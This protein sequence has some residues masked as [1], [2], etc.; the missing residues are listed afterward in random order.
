[1]KRTIVASIAVLVLVVAGCSSSDPTAS[2]E[3]QAIE[4]E[5]AA[6]E[7]QLAETEQALAEA[8]QEASEPSSKASQAEAEISALTPPDEVVLLLEEWVAALNRSDG[9][10]VELY[11]PNGYHLYGTEKIELKD[12]EAHLTGATANETITPPILIVDEGDGRYVVTQGY[13]NTV[14]GGKYASA[15]TYT[16]VT[17]PGGELKIAYSEWTYVVR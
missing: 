3:Y 8:Q 13:R 9:S 17:E 1:M 16:I 15:L 10:V 7:Q 11:R 6:A 2:D 14:G 12:V 5:L 4:Q